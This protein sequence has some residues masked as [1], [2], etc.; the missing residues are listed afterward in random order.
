MT[1]NKIDNL[2]SDFLYYKDIQVEKISKVYVCQNQI[3]LLPTS[4]I[5]KILEI[6]KN[7]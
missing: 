3:C 1:I 2:K 5:K 7:E 6:L 4:D